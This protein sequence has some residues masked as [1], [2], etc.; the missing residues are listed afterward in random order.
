MTNGTAFCRAVYFLALSEIG[1]GGCSGTYMGTHHTAHNGQRNHTGCQDNAVGNCP[2]QERNV[3][4]VFNRSTETNDGQRTDHTEGQNHVGGNDLD[5]Q[6][7]DHGDHDHAAGK[8]AAEADAGVGDAV[9]EHDEQAQQKAQGDG[10][11]HLT[12]G[13]GGKFLDEFSL[14]NINEINHAR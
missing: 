9:D 5:H 6:G 14:N 4:R 11:Q 2:E 1:I 13:D 10:N 3:Q 12:H 8:V 7:G